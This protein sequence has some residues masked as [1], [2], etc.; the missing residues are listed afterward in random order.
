MILGIDALAA[1]G[2][3]V[4]ALILAPTLVVAV[5]QGVAWSV[6]RARAVASE[7][8]V[9]G[10]RW[11][12]MRALFC[13][14]IPQGAPSAPARFDAEVFYGSDYCGRLSAENSQSFS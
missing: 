6:R 1:A 8:V 14:A 9:C 12:G 3:G 11:K 2:L 4:L 10:P 13:C 7:S 5:L